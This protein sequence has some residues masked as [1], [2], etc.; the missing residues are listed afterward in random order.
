ML[1]DGRPDVYM[2]D[3]KLVRPYM[4]R[5]PIQKFMVSLKLKPVKDGM[6]SMMRLGNTRWQ[7]DNDR[8]RHI[9]Q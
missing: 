9:D 7:C 2:G 8:F 4:G 6:V 5:Q 1:R 3:T